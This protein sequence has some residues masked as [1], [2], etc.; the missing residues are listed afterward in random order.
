MNVADLFVFEFLPLPDEAAAFCLSPLD[1]AFGSPWL[2]LRETLHI[3]RIRFRRSADIAAVAVNRH[4][5]PPPFPC[6]TSL[7][8]SL[9]PPARLPFTFEITENTDI[10]INF[11]L[12]PLP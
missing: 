7:P 3:D 11:P 2:R 12:H 8:A 5:L 10:S 1:P 6:L 9:S 4:P